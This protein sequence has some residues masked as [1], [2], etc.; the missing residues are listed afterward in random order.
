MESSQ[1]SLLAQ[2]KQGD[3]KAIA[4]LLNQKLLSKGITVKASVKSR[5]LHIMLEA[6]KTPQQQP[7]LDFIRKGLSGLAVDS[8]CGV[9]VYGRR[10]GEEI[11]EWVEEFKIGRAT[12]DLTTLAK[13]GDVKAITTLINQQLQA[14]GVV[15]K[16][17]AKN[18]LFSVMLE[19][20][21]VPDKE[22]MVA[23]LQSTF[24]E[25]GVHGIN[26]LRLYGKQSGEDFPD[27]QE[28]IKLLLDKIESQEVQPS[29]L[30][31]SPL[32]STTEQ[33]STL[34]VIQKFDSVSLS[35]HLYTA[36]QT[37]C[38]QNLSYKV[39]SENE[40]T[41]HEIVEDFVDS[42]EIDLKLDLD[43]FV[44]QVF[45]ILESF[46]LQADQA[47]IQAMISNVTNSNFTGVKLAIRDLERVKREVLQTDF[48][49]ETDALKALFAGAAQGFTSQMFSMN[50][51]SQEAVIGTAIGTAIAPG[52][53]SVIGGAIGGWLGGNKQQKVL[54]QLIEKYQKARD[55]VLLEWESLLQ[56]V[57]AKLSDFVYSK[58]SVKLLDFQIMDQAIDFYNQGNEYLEKDLEKSLKFYDQAIQLN[59][60]FAL[61]W[62]N[63]GY[64][65]NQLKRFEEALSVINQAL[66]INQILVIALH[67]RGDALQGL[68]KNQEAIAAY[69]ESI[70]LDQT[71]YQAWRGI[72]TCLYNLQHYDEAIIV[73]QKLVELDSENF[74]GWYAKAV[75]YAILGDKE[76]AIENLRES[77]SLDSESA[78]RLAKSDSDF[79]RL[80]ENEL[81]KELMESSVGVSY[82]SLKKYLKQK[83]W[84][85]ADQ[86]TARLIKEVIQ[87]VTNSTEVNKENLKAFPCTDLETIDS[88][89]RENSEGK[90]GFSMQK[91]I[92]EES[93]KD[94]EIF[95]AK[96]GWRIN[97]AKGNWSWRSNA[98]FDYNSESIPDGYLPSS[99]WAGE[100][101]WFEN[102][103]DRL[104]T[105]LARMESTT[106]A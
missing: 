75:C 52:I 85:E 96:N 23:L 74:L 77:V 92:F 100:D 24:Q 46:D 81:F 69:Q 57:Y 103:R 25:L 98:D 45:D 38:Y 36:L 32:P 83:Q 16:V 42:L 97:D 95:G 2:A 72:E 34:S 39:G 43:N 88:F 101:G 93:S 8:W 33:V 21:E 105:L 61:A 51:M 63:K 87:K 91:K 80:R 58:T 68:G 15:A 31:L 4:T 54:E 104:I 27:W 67:N 6:S 30:D 17:R 90:F 53:G 70:N 59:P 106:Q 73:A 86:E 48:P 5:Y 49:Q 66:Q 84:R 35:N 62:N 47:K 60:G 78:Q 14:S 37:T 28:E 26:S 94:K 89:W 41:I 19:A 11:P 1:A 50:K 79:D 20:V 99:L 13:Q 10:A 102:R 12:N 9:K 44:K 22:Q 3:A 40:K 18:D 65:L 29:S 71:N 76:L 56:I 64:A 7:L 82:M 55:K